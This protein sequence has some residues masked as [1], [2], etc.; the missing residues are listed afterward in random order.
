MQ[1]SYSFSPTKL[2]RRSIGLLARNS[3]RIVAYVDGS[4]LPLGRGG[5]GVVLKFG[6][7]TVE[8]GRQLA[9]SNSVLSEL[10]AVETVLDLTPRSKSLLIKT[11]CRSVFELLSHNRRHRRLRPDFK[12]VRTKLRGRDTEV[13]FVT[14]K[15]RTSPAYDRADALA[16]NSAKGQA[17]LKVV[18]N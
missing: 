6:K 14:K 15:N 9:A 11:D 3:E 1:E 8:V 4:A 17:H 13:R 5:L 7:F 12:R 16:F 2:T 18:F 10:S